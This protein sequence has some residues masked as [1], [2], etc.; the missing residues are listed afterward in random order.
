M[1]VLSNINLNSTGVQQDTFSF[2]V[3][4][5][6]WGLIKLFAVIRQWAAVFHN[7]SNHLAVQQIVANVKGIVVI[8]KDRECMSCP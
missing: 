1:F 5:Y 4:T 3:V 6:F 2:S 8:R 7:T